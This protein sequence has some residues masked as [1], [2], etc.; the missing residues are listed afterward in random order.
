M[1]LTRLDLGED[2]YAAAD[3]LHALRR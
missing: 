1:V 2:P 3:V